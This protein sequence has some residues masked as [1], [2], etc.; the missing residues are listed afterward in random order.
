MFEFHYH[1]SRNSFSVYLFPNVELT[2]PGFITQMYVGLTQVP[3][4]VTRL[5]TR[6][7]D[8]YTRAGLPEICQQNGR[9]T[10]RDN[11]GHSTDNGH[12]RSPSI[13]IKIPHSP[14]TR[15]RG[16]GPHQIHK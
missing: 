15:N 16:A 7:L 6:I 10:A 4:R 11:T 1:Y 2:V 3:V 12:I 8:I 13:E 9:A 14:R 5:W